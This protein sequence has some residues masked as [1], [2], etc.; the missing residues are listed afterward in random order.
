MMVLR[1]DD[2]YISDTLTMRVRSENLKRLRDIA[3]VTVG[4]PGNSLDVSVVLITFVS[5]RIQRLHSDDP[6]KLCQNGWIDDAPVG[7]RPMIT[8]SD[9][10]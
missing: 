1:D 10:G 2:H 7:R 4:G 3:A 6:S 5:Q 8:L 9:A